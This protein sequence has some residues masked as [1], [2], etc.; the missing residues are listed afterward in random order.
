MAQFRGE[1]LAV[2]LLAAAIPALVA[3]LY[4][5]STD[6]SS[7]LRWNL[8]KMTLGTFRLSL[9][10]SVL[11]EEGWGEPEMLYYRDG[12]STT[13]S[14][15]R[16]GRHY[17]LKN[18]GKV[19]ASNGGDMPTQILV[20]AYPLL[21][22]A[23]DPRQSDVAIVGFGSGVTVG[24][25]LQFPVRS[26]DVIELE[27]SVVQASRF[28]ADVNHLR[29]P[30][31]RYPWV[32]MPRLNVYHDDARNY[33]A[34]SKKR[35]HVII[36]EPS[37]P[38]LTGVSDLFTADHFRAAKKH[39]QPGGIYCQWVQLY[40]ISPENVKAI[41]RTFAEHFR[42]VAVFSAEARSSDTIL[43]GSDAPLPIDLGR[44][45]A[46]M[47][48]PSVT[49]EL[50]RA[51][52][53]T[54]FD[55]FARV[56]LASREDVLRYTQ[57]ETRLSKGRWGTV[58]D[59]TNQ[60]PCPPASCRRDQARLNTDDNALIEFAAP[61][62]LIGFERY[63][64]YLQTIYAQD[65]P[66]ARISAHVSGFGKERDD[67][68]KQALALI[69]HGRMNEGKRFERLAA[70]QGS[71]S[72]SSRLTELLALLIHREREIALPELVVATA[73]GGQGNTAHDVADALD[74]AKFALARKDYATALKKIDSIPETKRP[75]GNSSLRL[76][77]A[78]LLYK[79]SDY[80]SAIDQLE[81][82]IRID[83]PFAAR[84]PATYFF[85]S[86]AQYAAELFD[87]S[88]RNM[89]RYFELNNLSG[90]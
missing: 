7:I 79:T 1:R 61:R 4:V 2:N 74:E 37:N 10:K 40:E 55:L 67:Y 48:E 30:L 56:L 27:S 82:L 90:D 35:Y 21:M 44:V 75:D 68:L 39:L 50:K 15:E 62:D 85:L 5:S 13:V 83:E 72:A 53:D 45:R 78:Y 26:V 81:E 54:P 66:Y 89:R 9:A 70:A 51:D 34:A 24:A 33:L 63:S 59:S 73:F 58:A 8:A 49:A 12:L 38:W 84:C 77:E 71:A 14:V 16:W 47:A 3:I 42:Y 43:L 86:R 18:N 36:S 32:R 17:M 29:Y 80:Q 52:V 57:I 25:A 19:D 28:F 64:G 6:P 46:H 60:Q 76:V 41:Y 65:W 87:K 22:H 20:A 88:V 11:D 31:E 23:G 69:A